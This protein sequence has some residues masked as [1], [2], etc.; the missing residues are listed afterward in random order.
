MNDYTAP[1]SDPNSREGDDPRVTHMQQEVLELRRE[2]SRLAGQRQE[3]VDRFNDHE[4]Q[5]LSVADTVRELRGP[6]Q[7]VFTAKVNTDGSWTEQT[8]IGDNFADY[9]AGGRSGSNTGAT[10]AVDLTTQEPLLEVEDSG[11]TRFIR[12]GGSKPETGYR[13]AW[14]SNCA[15]SGIYLAKVVIDPTADI[16]VGTDLTEAHLGSLPASADCIVVNA[17]EVNTPGSHLWQDW[18]NVYPSGVRIML[19]SASAATLPGK[20]VIQI[21]MEIPNT[22]ASGQVLVNHGG[23][24]NAGRYT[25]ES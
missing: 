3:Y 19:Q 20:P 23:H 24:W 12:I 7:K 1:T 11:D 21:C 9:S 2:I 4:F 18:P 22:T 15:G 14:V 5:I 13:V 25:L 6:R 17:A 10:K 8:L 16:V